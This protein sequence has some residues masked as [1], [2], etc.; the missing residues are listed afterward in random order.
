MSGS[1]DLRKA[2]SVKKKTEWWAKVSKLFKLSFDSEAEKI[3]FTFLL[4]DMNG[5]V[6]RSESEQHKHYFAE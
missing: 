2:N 6:Y 3:R 1:A 4:N 5:D